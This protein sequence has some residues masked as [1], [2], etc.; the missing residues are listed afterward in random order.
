MC[1]V[2]TL[3][4]AVYVTLQYMSAQALSA[5]VESNVARMQCSARP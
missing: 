3:A 4:N 2:H 5:D 1:Y